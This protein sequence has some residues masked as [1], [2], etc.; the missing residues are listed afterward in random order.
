MRALAAVPLLASVACG[1]FGGDSANGDPKDA[2]SSAR[3]ESS[4]EGG[5]IED[6]RARSSVDCDATFCESFEEE[7]PAAGLTRPEKFEPTFGEG[8]AS[9][10][11]FEVTTDKE[12]GTPRFLRWETAADTIHL[13]RLRFQLNVF[14]RPDGVAGPPDAI[15]AGIEC[16]DGGAVLLKVKPTQLHL[17][18]QTKT[19]AIRG[20]TSSAL[21]FGSWSAIDLSWDFATHT[22]RLDGGPAGLLDLAP[23]EECKKGVKVSFGFLAWNEPPPG[24]Y[25][26]RIDDVKI[27]VQ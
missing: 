25:G 15:V 20:M 24:F 27:D 14:G 9:K 1:S 21:V 22:V 6:G 10:R 11:S 2:G 17:Q 13:V 26:V 8:F 18:L 23:P 4:T 5:A 7:P 3:P 16:V 19:E 12:D